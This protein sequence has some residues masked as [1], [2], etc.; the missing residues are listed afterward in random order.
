LLAPPRYC[1][2]S[3]LDPSIAYQDSSSTITRNTAIDQ[4]TVGINKSILRDAKIF[5]SNGE[6]I[7][8]ELPSEIRHLKIQKAK[9]QIVFEIEIQAKQDTIDIYNLGRGVFIIQFSSPKGVDSKKLIF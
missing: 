9:V 5:N 4:S 6:L 3:A 1:V 8:R 7:I 2:F